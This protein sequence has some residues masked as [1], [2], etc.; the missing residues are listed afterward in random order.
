MNAQVILETAGWYLPATLLTLAISLAIVMT[1]NLHIHRTAKGHAGQEIQSVHTVPTPRIGGLA[2]FPGLVLATLLTPNIT[3][4]YLGL[5]LI[6]SGPVFAAGLRE[7]IGIGASAK[8]R[9]MA[10]MF[11]SMLMIIFTNSTIG[12]GVAPGID[13]LLSFFVISAVFTIF[14]T[15]AVCHAFNLIDGMNGL[16]MLVAIVASLALC[17][18]ALQFDDLP[19]AM[20]AGAIAAATLGVLL[21]NYPFGKLF[22]GDAGAYTLGFVIAWTG[23]LIIS[24]NPDVSRWSVLLTVFWPFID[25]S[26]AVLRRITKKVRIA[27]P[28]KMHFHHVIMRAIKANRHGSASRKFANPL[29]TLTL[30]PFIALP[31]V[32]GS[33]TAQNTMLSFLCLVSSIIAYFFIQITIIRH[34]RKLSR[35]SLVAHKAKRTTPDSANPIGSAAPLG[36][37]ETAATL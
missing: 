22:L 21:L 25:T 4:P 13:T 12:S 23:V 6:A 1:R 2:L 8:Q 7:D 30:F 37:G 14:T 3:G 17:S 28:D 9:L 11:S 5:A 31:P 10:A 26:A 18:I 20:M 19:M 27:A 16:A 33:A 32:L 35:I 36:A 34:F 24:R 15:A 29:T